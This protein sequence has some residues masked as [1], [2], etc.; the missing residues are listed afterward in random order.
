M[1]AKRELILDRPGF[2]PVSLVV[3][4]MRAARSFY[5]KPRPLTKAALPRLNGCAFEIVTPTKLAAFIQDHFDVLPRTESKP[6]LVMEVVMTILNLACVNQ[7]ESF[8]PLPKLKRGIEE[9]L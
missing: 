7:S 2:G 1:I 3:D 4:A 8:L 9:L 6:H 5:V